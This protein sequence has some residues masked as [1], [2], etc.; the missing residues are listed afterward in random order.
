MEWT[1]IAPRLGLNVPYEWWPSAP[2]LKGIEAEG[3]AWV[4]LPSPPPSVLSD[5]R[6]LERHSSALRAALETSALRR[7]LHAP[8]SLR[9][10]RGTATAP[11]RGCS[12]TPPAWARS[13]SSIAP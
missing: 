1:G 11:S 2:L 9:S 5:A 13:C 3:F 12:T 8:G 10:A 4:Q 6:L 7:M